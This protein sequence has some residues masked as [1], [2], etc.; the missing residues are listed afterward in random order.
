MTLKI[1]HVISG[2]SPESGGPTIAVLEIARWQCLLGHS[3]TILTAAER[4]AG[5]PI[6]LFDLFHKAGGSLTEFPALGPEKIRYMPQLKDYLRR[7]GRDFDLYVLHGSY[8]YPTYT[9]ARFCRSEKIPYIFTPHGSLDPAVRNKHRLRNR[10][11][12]FTYHDRVIGNADAWHFTSREERAACERPIWTNSFIEPLGIDVGRIPRRSRS[13]R[14]RKKYGIP[15]E[16]ILLTFLSRIT[17]KKGIDI[18]LDAFRRIV[19]TSPNVFLALCGPVDPDMRGLVEAAQRA[20]DVAV[21]LTVTGLLLGDDKDDAFLDSDCF[22]LP[23]YSENFGIAAFEALAY[24]VPLLTTTGMNLHAELAKSGRAMIVEP[25]ADALYSGMLDVV[26]RK[27][28]PTATP[29]ETRSWLERNFSWRV[30]AGNLIQH[31]SGSVRSGNAQQ[32]RH[33]AA[34]DLG[35]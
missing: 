29:D 24:G 21:R 4:K 7:R 1:A 6:D 28:Q 9:V 25:N 15:E 22:V 14:F 34:S 18:L 13:E 27:W 16:A 20:P 2:L 3:C 33:V 10:M 11:V 31:Y 5:A 35:R 30:R 26:N 17:R 8:Q 32:L 23:T 12:D 19:A